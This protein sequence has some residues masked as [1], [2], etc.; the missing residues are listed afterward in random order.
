MAQGYSLAHMEGA[1]KTALEEQEFYGTDANTEN[2]SDCYMIATM[3]KKNDA[4]VNPIVDWTDEMIWEYVQK[5][6]IDMSKYITLDKNYYYKDGQYQDKI[7]TYK[8]IDNYGNIT[9]E[10][11]ISEDVIYCEGYYDYNRDFTTGNYW[12][13]EVSQ[14]PEQLLFWFD[15][16]DAEGSDIAKYSV[17][18]I[19]SRTKAVKDTNV[20]SIYYREIPTTIFQSG[21]EIYEHQ[22]GYTYVQLQNTMENLFT[23][24]SK[25]I[26]AKERIEEFLN[27]YIYCAANINI[28]AFNII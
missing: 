2:P 5:E 6:N 22:P 14:N 21:V 27:D 11:L 13:K 19:G 12:A 23:I 17:P 8:S 28:I 3:K 1:Y 24:S 4:N 10:T 26:S 18:A 9:D 7:Y 16:L 15:F 20:K 25:G